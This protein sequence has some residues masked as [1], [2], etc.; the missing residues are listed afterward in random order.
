MDDA[1]VVTFEGGPLRGQVK[2]VPAPPLGTLVVKEKLGSFDPDF[3]AKIEVGEVV[4]RLDP[5]NIYRLAST[6]RPILADWNLK[7]LREK[8]AAAKDAVMPISM[9]PEA[10][11]LLVDAVLRL[12]PVVRWYADE[13]NYD[14]EN[15]PGELVSS[16]S[17]YYGVDEYDWEP[18]GGHRALQALEGAS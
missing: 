1:V 9:N 4:Y 13:R 15:C 8:L 14:D 17:D 11:E 16:Y 7:E 5:G 18:D 12:E 3:N 6:P 10:V 2:A